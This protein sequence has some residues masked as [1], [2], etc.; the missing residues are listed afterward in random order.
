[1]EQQKEEVPGT[2]EPEEIED[3]SKENEDPSCMPRAS[4]RRKSEVKHCV[5]CSQMKCK[6]DK[7]LYRIETELRA[8]ELLAACKFFKDDVHTNCLL[9]ENAGDVFA[10][11]VLYHRNCLNYYILK[12]KRELKA[13]VAVIEDGE[14]KNG[15]TK[16]AVEKIPTDVAPSDMD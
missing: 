16:T 7:V 14:N 1:L 15:V 11:D 8:K 12:F 2:N 4:K 3:N 10:G 5:V 6:G 9:M 13:L